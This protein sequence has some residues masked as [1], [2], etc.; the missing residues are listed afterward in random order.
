MVPTNN[1]YYLL[2]HIPTVQAI[3]A[4]HGSETINGGREERPPLPKRDGGGIC[5]VV[6]R[7]PVVAVA[8]HAR[9]R[10]SPL[11][12]T[13]AATPLFLPPA[14]SLIH[15]A[16]FLPASI[17]VLL[18]RARNPTSLLVAPPSLSHPRRQ[19]RRQ[20]AQRRSHEGAIAGGRQATGHP[21][22]VVVVRVLPPHGHPYFGGWC[23]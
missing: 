6:V 10:P 8:R 21:V 13:N 18:T 20:P 22:R 23:L 15:P 4:V 19:Q 3:I 12:A 16:L 5:H 1:S 7:L 11:G 17:F 2:L 14:L 9:A